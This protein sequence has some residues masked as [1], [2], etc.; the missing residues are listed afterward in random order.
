MKSGWRGINGSKY[1]E[2]AIDGFKIMVKIFWRWLKGMDESK[3]IY[4]PEVSWIASSKASQRRVT[5]TRSDLLS[6]EE[7]DLFATA[8]GDAQDS[9]LVKVL[10]DDA[11]GRIS[12]ILT[13]RIGCRAASLRVQD[14]RVGVEN[15]R[16]SRPIPI[17]KSAPAFARWLS[18][19]PF[20]DSPNAPLWL[21]SYKQQM[22][23]G[24]GEQKMGLIVRI[25]LH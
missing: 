24:A 9:A 23:Y 15:I 14:E 8:T 3:P 10:D 16:P 5:V 4:P 20:R 6:P 7:I 2:A 1:S 25:R 11:G 17:A 12:E 18:L 21:N 22:L 13:L 19:H